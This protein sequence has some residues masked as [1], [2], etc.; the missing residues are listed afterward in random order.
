MACLQHFNHKEEVGNEYDIIKH[1]TKMTS[2]NDYD[3]M[4]TFKK[5]ST[6]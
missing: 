3:I 2:M 1:L 5:T 4:E 6:G